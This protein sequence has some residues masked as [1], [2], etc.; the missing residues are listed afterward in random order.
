LIGYWNAFKQ[1]RIDTS[2]IINPA[3]PMIQINNTQIYFYEPST[4][5]PSCIM[6]D[7]FLYEKHNDSLIIQPNPFK[8]TLT[9]ILIN[10]TLLYY[11][12]NNANSRKTYFVKYYDKF[13]PIGWPN[14]YCK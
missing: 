4:N 5:N 14:N 2:A 9:V 11:Q 13:P 12:S 3:L 1:I 6:T 8:D 10:D 7:T